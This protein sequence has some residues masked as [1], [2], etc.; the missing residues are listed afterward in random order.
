M[1][2]NQTMHGNAMCHANSN[3]LE[4]T[5]NDNDNVDALTNDDSATGVVD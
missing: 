2:D 1:V 5:D 4:S 3:D